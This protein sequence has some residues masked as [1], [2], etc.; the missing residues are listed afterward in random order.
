MNDMISNDNFCDVSILRQVPE[1]GQF[2]QFSFTS[3]Q[4]MQNSQQSNGHSTHQRVTSL[5]LANLFRS[6][7]WRHTSKMNNKRYLLNQ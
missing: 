2:H 5:N 7:V 1:I 4:P 6:E 3:Q